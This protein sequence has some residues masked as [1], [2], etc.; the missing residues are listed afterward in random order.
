MED[1]RTNAGATHPLKLVFTQLS[2]PVPAGPPN[3]PLARSHHTLTVLGNKAVIFGGRDASGALCPPG[4]HTLT[5][6]TPNPSRSRTPQ[7]PE[8]T[9]SP[10]RTSTP[11]PVT[12]YYTSYP[13]Y[14]LHDDS[15]GELLLP[16]PRAE[17]AACARDREG[18]FLL[19]HGGRLEEAKNGTKSEQRREEPNRNGNDKD[20]EDDV[21][22]NNNCMW[23]WDT[24]H[25]R[26]MKLRGETQIGESMAAPRWGHWI[27]AD[28]DTVGDE[29]DGRG[30]EFVILIGGRTASCAGHGVPYPESGTQRQAWMYDLH[31]GVWTALPALPARPLAAAYADKRVYVLS[32]GAG[33]D[34]H[35]TTVV[36]YLDLHVSA[37]E[38]ERRGAL[39]WQKVPKHPHSHAHGRGPEP[40]EGGA[41]I[42]LTTRHGREYLVYMFGY[43]DSNGE[44]KFHSDVW[45]LQIPAKRHTLAAMTDKLRE[46]LLPGGD[47]GEWHWAQAEVVLPEH[48]GA[49]AKVHPGPRAMFGADSCLDG[50][51]VVVWGGIGPQGETL[52]DGWLIKPASGHLDHGRQE[53]QV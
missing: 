14:T 5:L 17:H 53:H 36:H 15:T 9:A 39:V 37:V 51:G 16:C 28:R 41:L 35:P 50:H 10:H 40:R 46:T 45:T 31:A 20:E 6:P 13:P 25:L 43:S 7:S 19:V 22:D 11:N 12:S 30:Q 8:A 33:P 44:K 4:I 23:Q 2:V 49:D 38:R 27:F 1:S 24:K 52:S 32:N 42:P 3:P 47:S 34:G 18:R 29:D 26:W 21:D 48:N